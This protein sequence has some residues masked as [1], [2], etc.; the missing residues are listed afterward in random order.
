MRIR[1][2]HPRFYKLSKS[3]PSSFRVSKPQPGGHIWLQL[4]RVVFTTEPK[5]YGLWDSFWDFID[6][7]KPR[8]SR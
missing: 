4:G 8:F 3:L 6:S 7:V 1:D 5:D 2:I